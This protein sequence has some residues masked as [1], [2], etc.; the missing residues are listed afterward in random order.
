ME[1]I[2]EMG[3]FSIFCT[4]E[5]SSFLKEAAY[6]DECFVQSRVKSLKELSQHLRV[7][8]ADIFD[9]VHYRSQSQCECDCTSRDVSVWYKVPLPGRISAGSSLS[10]WFV[11]INRSLPSAAATPSN[12]LRSLRGER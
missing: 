10:I 4:S 11:V 8:V 3:L 9:S 2:S 6:R 1:N 7:R 5:F 12:A